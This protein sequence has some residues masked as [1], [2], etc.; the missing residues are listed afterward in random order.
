MNVNSWA[1][2]VSFSALICTL[3]EF[4]VPS[5]FQGKAVRIVVSVFF[6]ITVIEPV[7]KIKEIFN[8]SKDFIHI[9]ENIN[10]ENKYL[11]A[12]CVDAFKKSVAEEIKK[13]L[14]YI[15]AKSEKIFI[16]IKEDGG[17]CAEICL[18]EDSSSHELKN[19]IKKKLEEDFKISVKFLNEG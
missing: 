9:E 1:L 17:L 8:Y 15:G 2:M 3:V 11:T 5:N 6:L 13:F 16:S 18:N 12:Y 14:T 7:K 10:L 19:Q 4:L